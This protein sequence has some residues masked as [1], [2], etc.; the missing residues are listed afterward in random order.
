[1]GRFCTR[2]QPKDKN[3]RS[4]E[5]DRP[6][7]GALPFRP[8][9]GQSGCGTEIRK[10]SGSREDYVAI[11]HGDTACRATSGC[12][13]GKPDVEPRVP[14]WRSPLTGYSSFENNEIP[15]S[16]LYVVFATPLCCNAN[17]EVLM[18]G[19]LEA[20]LQRRAVK[21]FEPVE[22]SRG[23]ASKSS[24]QHAMLRPASTCSRTGSIG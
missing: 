9:Y 23:C 11:A 24:M 16:F 3:I 4:F 19:I 6:R 5:R 14:S 10:T 2:R 22:I 20:M 15:A 1:M 18:N 12:G 13:V 7:Q 21:V 17:M 8:G